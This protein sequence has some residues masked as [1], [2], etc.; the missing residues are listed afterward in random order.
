MSYPY[1]N[2]VCGTRRILPTIASMYTGHEYYGS[3]DKGAMNSLQPKEATW[4][5]NTMLNKYPQWLQNF[6]VNLLYIMVMCT[7]DGAKPRERGV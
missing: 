3:W 1:E 4:E 5:E 7:E 6:D 2:I